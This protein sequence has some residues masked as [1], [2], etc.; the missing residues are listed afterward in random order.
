MESV[1][2]TIQIASYSETDV[3]EFCEIVYN[4]SMRLTEVQ[5]DYNRICKKL[6]ECFE[7]VQ[8]IDVP[9]AFEYTK[10]SYK[11][12]FEKHLNDLLS[13]RAN[14][15]EFPQTVEVNCLIALN[16]NNYQHKKNCIN[17][18]D[19]LLSYFNVLLVNLEYSIN[20]CI[21]RGLQAYQQSKRI[22]CRCK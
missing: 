19:N 22:M 13:I 3:N 5:A 8:H 7:F 17:Y 16:A 20:H 6:E 4:C 11:H 14:I 21:N 12:A 2:Q 18:L 10:A 9:F 1:P 15:E